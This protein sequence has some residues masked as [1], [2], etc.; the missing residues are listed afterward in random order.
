MTAGPLPN[1]ARQ[2]TVYGGLYEIDAVRQALVDEFGDDG[3]PAEARRSFGQ[4]AMF[5][6]TVDADGFLVEDSGTLSSCAWAL[7]RLDRMGRDASGWLDGFGNETGDFTSALNRLTP[8]H[9]QKPTSGVGTAAGAV[10]RHTKNQRSTPSKLVP[11]RPAR[12]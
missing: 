8:P 7:G 4:S 11:P 1:R 10:G 2:Y 6:F 9:E 12:R 5:A 3:T